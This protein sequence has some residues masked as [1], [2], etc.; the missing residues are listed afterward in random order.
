LRSRLC[1]G[2]SSSSTLIS[3][4]H[5]QNQSSPGIRQTQIYPLDCQMVK[6]DLSLQ[7]THFHCSRVQWQRALHHS[8]WRLA[9][10]MI[11]GLCAAAQPWKPISRS[12]RRTVIVLMLLPEAVCKSVV[13]VATEDSRIFNSGVLQH[14]A[15]PFCELVWPTTLR[16]SHWCS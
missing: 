9:L 6:R 11:L 8:S 10:R 13:S 3:T 1:A 15:V 4:N 2:Q 5:F 16:L 14:S 12:S 7:R